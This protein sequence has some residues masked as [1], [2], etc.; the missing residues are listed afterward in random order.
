M[1]VDYKWKIPEVYKIIIPK[2]EDVKYVRNPIYCGAKFNYVD[3]METVDKIDKIIL[4]YRDRAEWKDLRQADLEF[5]RQMLI[6]DVVKGFAKG[7]IDRHGE[8]AYMYFY[9]NKYLEKRFNY[10]ITALKRR[11]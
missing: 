8:D 11:E 7:F 4:G 3:I 2:P 6:K 1:L 10:R 9:N 5:Q